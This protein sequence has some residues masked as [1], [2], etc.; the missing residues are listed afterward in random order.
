[1]YNSKT[2]Y[3]KKKW[4]SAG[5]GA[6]AANATPT[7][8]LTDGAHVSGAAAAPRVYE[9][10]QRKLLNRSHL[11]EDEAWRLLQLH[12]IPFLLFFFPFLLTFQFT[13]SGR[14]YGVRRKLDRKSVV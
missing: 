13:S 8:R 4:R 11:Q 5:R 2:K 10:R 9:R 6:G 3:Q 7:F 12:T 14:L 1:M